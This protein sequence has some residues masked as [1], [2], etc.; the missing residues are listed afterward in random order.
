MFT[1]L[2]NCMK[3]YGLFNADK[4]QVHF[5]PEYHKLFEANG[6]G[7]FEIFVFEENGKI[8]LYPFLKN[9]IDKIGNTYI[10]EEIYDI[11]SV[12]GYTG[13][14]YNTEDE[15]FLR[16][17]DEALIKYCHSHKII[18]EFIR[19]N[20]VLQNQKH[21]ANFEGFELF[22]I[23]NFLIVDLFDNE[24][25]LREQY[26]RR[27]LNRYINR[28]VKL[29]MNLEELNNKAEFDEFVALYMK[30]MEAIKVDKYFYFSNEYF[31][32]L[33]KFIQHK[34]TLF[35]VKN[36]RKMI[37]AVLFIYNN[38]TVYSHHSCRD[39]DDELSVA[40]NKPLFHFSFLKLGEYGF[41]QCML[42]GGN[43]PSEDD[44]LYLFKKSFSNKIVDLT[45]GK[46]IYEPDK[47]KLLCSI[48]EKE[49]PQ[50]TEK[51]KNFILKYRYYG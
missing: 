1:N 35:F 42:G 27:E 4:L 15:D 23:K 13:Y 46:R 6:D 45:G 47:Y 49:F 31:E 24:E 28:S 9:R 48:W 36:N 21:I 5:M 11:Q 38:D 7:K 18:V 51:R 3:Y 30:N 50:L 2:E 39:F 40:F 43:S 37:N 10:N 22:K 8:F 14:L 25:K 17:A 33:Y 44:S 26:N 32:K 29:G 20:P 34:G 16:K 19:F 12:F 41:K